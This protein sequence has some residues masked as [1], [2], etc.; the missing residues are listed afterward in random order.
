MPGSYGN[1]SGGMKFRRRTST[2]IQPELARDEVDRALDG[3]G[4]LGPAGAAVGVD[5]AGVRVDADRLAVDRRD[6][7]APESMRPYSVVGMPGAIVER[8]PPRFA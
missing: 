7:V 1:A 2:G 4:R 8:T 6:P 5:H 3:V